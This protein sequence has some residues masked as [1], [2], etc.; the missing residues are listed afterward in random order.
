MAFKW[1]RR[2]LSSNIDEACLCVHGKSLFLIVKRGL[3]R[4]YGNVREFLP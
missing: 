1:L 3:K 2:Q 4:V